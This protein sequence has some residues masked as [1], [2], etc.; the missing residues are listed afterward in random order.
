MD[1]WQREVRLFKQGS[2]TG[3][4]FSNI[5]GKGEKLSGGGVSSGLLS[6]LR[7]GD[8]A[9]GAIASGGTTRRSAKMVCLDL[10]HPEI[11]DFIDW[12]M[13]EELKAAQL[14]V[15][16][17]VINRHLGGGTFVD[18][19]T[20][21][22]IID[23][24]A[25]NISTPVCDLG[26][27]GEAMKTVSGQN[28][29][30]SV[31]PTESF[32]RAVEGDLEWA[33]I[34]RTTGKVVKKLKARDLWNKICTAAWASADPGL[35]YHDTINDWH[36]C[37]EDGRINAC[38]PCGEYQF[39]D[40][41]AC[42]LA[43]LNLYK[44]L[45][46]DKSFDVKSFT[47]ATRLLT[48]VLDISVE[49]ASFPSR[50]IAVNSQAYRTLGLGYS[51]LGGIL[52]RLGIGYDSDK[53][54]RLAAD[55]TALMT[56]VAYQTSA[57]M[58]EELGAFSAWER[59]SIPMRRVLEN[60]ERC[61]GFKEKDELNHW[62]ISPYV[63][64][65]AHYLDGNII[66]AAKK[67]WEKVSQ[68]NS[69]RNAQVTLLAPTGTIGLLMDCD[70]LGVE[71]DFSLKKFK[72]LSGGGMMQIVNECIPDA[73]Q[74]LGYTQSQITSI[75]QH[76]EE[77]GT[78]E[79]WKVNGHEIP[80]EHLSVFDCSVES[81]NGSR[82]LHPMSH[83]LMV[84]AVQPFLSGA[85]SKTTNMPGNSTIQDVDEIYK[86]ARDLGVKAIAL[87]RDGSKLTQPLN[88]RKEI[89]KGPPLA[90]FQ[91]STSNSQIP[92][93]TRPRNLDPKFA[94][95]PLPM[96]RKGY[97]Q[98]VKIDG[99]SIYL[100]TGDY[101]DSTL[102]E[103]FVNWSREGSTVRSLVECFAKAISIGLQHNVPLAKF[104]E[105]FVYTKFEPAGIVEGHDNIKT[106]TSI[107]D[108][109]FRDL[110]ISYL[111]QKE[112][113]NVV[114]LEIEDESLKAA[115]PPEL[116]PRSVITQTQTQT[117]IQAQTET[118]TQP[119]AK[120]TGNICPNCHHATLIQTGPCVTCST[121]AFNTGCG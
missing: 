100:R 119:T 86:R 106:T 49:M 44:F 26:F 94:R 11:E 33:L 4:N 97:T 105:A 50:E 90:T 77:T 71:P 30:N 70:T 84:A 1:L 68:A 6:F 15:G 35:L 103:I 28:A 24:V 67:A 96:K 82:A 63:P 34:A 37:R 108:F 53:G 47:H 2:G 99:Q 121:C 52:M 9:A 102:G 31:R 66:S 95:F 7:I 45:N 117:Q 59:N 89:S 72:Y 42:N 75:K 110:A 78:L 3:S 115:L 112:F 81:G 114:T 55:I 120:N 14:Y 21:Q 113:A 109:I 87:Y 25:N 61:M 98:K 76:V 32:F 54:R 58:A 29:N 56:G 60:H 41:T 107:L 18:D 62:L 36:T 69:F 111:K 27:E 116:V 91:L 64:N 5:R 93:E 39:L 80:E 48:I 118:Q 85:V 46:K 10:D 74:A 19:L 22:A 23:R 57:E 43:S 65:C 101:P 83:V 104:V 51:N 12:K 73:L 92:A 88:S 40:N 79:G 38:N 13:N 8:E 16:G 20:P 17:E